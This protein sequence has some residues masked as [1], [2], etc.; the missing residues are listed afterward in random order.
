MTASERSRPRTHPEW[1]HL[2]TH[3]DEEISRPPVRPLPVIRSSLVD[4]TSLPRGPVRSRSPE[5]DRAPPRER[6]GSS[7]R[8]ARKRYPAADSGES[9]GFGARELL[10]PVSEAAAEPSHRGFSI[11]LI[12][13]SRRDSRN[14]S[15]TSRAVRSSVVAPRAVLSAGQP[16]FRVRERRITRIHSTVRTPTK[17]FSTPNH[18]SYEVPASSDGSGATK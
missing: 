17:R 18:R 11:A 14:C 10:P 3:G 1:P 2:R 16:V 13:L 5:R 7:N 15:E 8:I 6:A 12:N 9:P 4:A